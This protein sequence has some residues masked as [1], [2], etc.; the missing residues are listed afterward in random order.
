MAL[1]SLDIRRYMGGPSLHCDML[2]TLTR[3]YAIPALAFALSVSMAGMLPQIVRSVYPLPHHGNYCDTMIG[4]LMKQKFQTR[5]AELS[6]LPELEQIEEL[7]W[8]E[9]LRVKAE[10][11][12]TRLTISPMNFVCTIDDQVVAAL[13]MQRIAGQSALDRATYHNV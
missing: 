3:Q 13:Y 12:K 11:L 6:D 8:S 1:G 2:N 10:V 9:R 4:N 5:L 7:A